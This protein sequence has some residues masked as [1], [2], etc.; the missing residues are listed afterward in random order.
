MSRAGHHATAQLSSTAA[1]LSA[2][3][4]LEA[5]VEQLQGEWSC[6]RHQDLG[7]CE[8]LRRWVKVTRTL[9]GKRGSHGL[10]HVLS[11]V[12]TSLD[13]LDSAATDSAFALAAL[14]AAAN[15]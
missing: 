13:Q 2:S 5:A 7:Q 10:Q 12:Q 4:A 3:S 14:L 1:L 9:S 6:S 11:G 15:A 8:L